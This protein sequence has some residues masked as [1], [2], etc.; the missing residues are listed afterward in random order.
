M[1]LQLLVFVTV[2]EKK[3]FSRAA[4]TLNLTQ[5]A[6]SQQIHSLE[7][8]YQVKLFE[9]NNKRVELTQAGEIL[10]H[11]ALQIL[12]LHQEAYQAI[13]DLL[14]LV[15]GKLTI[16]ASLTIGEYVL[17]R[18]LFH[19]T[20]QYP[21]VEIAVTIGNTEVIAEHA[22]MNRID[23][24]LVEG[25]VKPANLVITPFLEDELILIVPPNHRFASK[26][27]VDVSE[28]ENE[29]FIVREA[30]SGTRFAL[31]EILHSLQIHP[32]RDIQFGSTQ[33]IKEAVEVGLGVS[34][35]SKWGIQKELKLKTLS[36]LRVKGHSL[37]REFSVL[38]KKDRFQSRAMLEFSKLTLS[39]KFI[40]TVKYF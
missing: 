18:L 40:V 21:D 36:A 11:Y 8:H 28:L 15:T 38:W 1:H 31:T 20:Q 27:E 22:L 29:V 30:G 12:R 25:P 26:S 13:S 5:P 33:A 17:P 16:G 37:V 35:I 39:P 34:F 3:N 7:D 4:E 23:I 32:R 10:Y 24:G 2:V 19:Y 9:R 6:V 14:G